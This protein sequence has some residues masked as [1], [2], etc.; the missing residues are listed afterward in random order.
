[1]ADRPAQFMDKLLRP[2]NRLA[3]ALWT[4]LTFNFIN[5]SHK[6]PDW[7]SI[8]FWPCRLLA[9]FFGLA[10]FTTTLSRLREFSCSPWWIVAFTLPWL[11]L[12]CVFWWDPGRIGIV[13][14]VIWLVAQ[15]V[16]IF[17]NDRATHD[18]KEIEGTA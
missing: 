2:K 14:L 5:D 4:V 10:W 8:A 3:Y 15:S 12:I 9:T 11:A 13:A 18:A 17:K 6:I 16:L 1:M 7:T